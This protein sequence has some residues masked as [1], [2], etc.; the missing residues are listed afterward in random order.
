MVVAVGLES[1]GGNINYGLID[2]SSNPTY[3]GY[4]IAQYSKFVPP[5]SVRVSATGAPSGVL[6]SAY[7]GSTS[8]AIVAINSN[9]SAVSLPVSLQNLTISSVTPY[10]TTSAGGLQQQ[11]AVTV[12]NGSFTYTLPG[13]S[14]VTFVSGSSSSTCNSTPPAPTGLTATASS[15][16][17]INLSWTATTAPSG[18]SISAYK[19]FRS[20]TSG[21]TPSSSNQIASVASGTIFSD[22]GL[23]ASTTYYYV[24]E[25]ADSEGSSAASAQASAETS[26]SSSG[27]FTL[28]PS[29]SSLS[30]TRGATTTDTITVSDTGGFTGSVTLSASGLPSGITA[31][32]GTNPTTGSSVITFAAT[33]SATVG[34][35]IVTVVG[36]SGTTTANTSITL[37]V[38]TSVQTSGFACHVIYAVNNQWPSGF[39]AAITLENTGTTNWTSWTLTWSFANGQTITQL[40]NGAETQSGAN[41]TVSNLSY[42][43]SIPA[44]GSYNGMGFNGTWNNS[45][46]S[47]PSSFAINGTACH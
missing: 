45:T 36:T 28:A 41:I 43:G 39:G 5:G 33:S 6:V 22:T 29:A 26:A 31:T 42:N 30:V 25:A 27:S 34:T 23:T 20:T 18:C 38:N 15:S 47:V 17:G 4:A 21:F 35:A 13:Q 9:S 7:K 1:G 32:F 46:N 11:N 2:T 12:T 37:T 19:V 10:Q 3:Y 16:S 14:I 8:N 24:V 40:W 44:G